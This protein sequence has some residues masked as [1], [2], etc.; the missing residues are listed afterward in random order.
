MLQKEPILLIKNIFP[1]TSLN[2]NY[3]NF[4]KNRKSIASPE[5]I[6]KFKHEDWVNAPYAHLVGQTENKN[7]FVC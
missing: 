6:A 1:I 7:H 3:E 2:Q 5:R 4:R